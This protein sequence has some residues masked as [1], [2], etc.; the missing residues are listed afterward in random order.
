MIRNFN[1]WRRAWHRVYAALTP[2][3][4]PARLATRLS[5]TFDV[6]VEEHEVSAP[7]PL[8]DASALRLGFASDLHA[9]PATPWPVLEKGVAMLASRAPDVVLLG[10][11]YVG[12]DLSGMPRLVELIGGLRPPLGVHAV[13]G[14]HDHWTDAP[15]IV[16]QL[17]RAGVRLLTNRCQRL[18]AP[19]QHVDLCGIDD[20]TSGAP[21]ADAAFA[22]AGPNRVLLMHSPSSLLDV[23]ER[24]FTVAMCGHTHGGQVSFNGW[25]LIVPHGPL[26]RRYNSGRFT[27]AGDRT[28][29]VSRGLG[30]AVLPLRLH[31]PA[32]ILM[33]RLTHSGV[34]ATT[35]R[36]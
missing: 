14:N 22:G 4:W 16:R 30:F 36:R 32:S 12:H 17:E 34:A 28:L 2:G 29:L 33:C 24:P 6:A 20:F 21:D 18:P 10:G 35:D 25:P 1:R 15:G 9:G 5:P 3:D 19:W 11:D 13:L 26:S 23:G 8:G 27:L 7:T 31:A